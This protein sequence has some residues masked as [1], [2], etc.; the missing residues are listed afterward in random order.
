M[1]RLL[2]VVAAVVAMVS[3]PSTAS[4]QENPGGCREFGQL[5][6]GLAHEAQP[7]GQVVK[8]LAPANDE[9]ASEFVALCR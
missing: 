6:A 4:A 2:F 9:I 7:F 1:K 3:V 8:G 5:T